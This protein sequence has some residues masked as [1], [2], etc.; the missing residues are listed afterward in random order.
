MC[1]LDARIV[2]KGRQAGDV[3]VPR[4]TVSAAD[5]EAV[6]H[7]AGMDET[8]ARKPSRRASISSEGF[9]EAMRAH[10]AD[11][12]G[13]LKAFLDDIDGIG[14]RPE[15]LASLNLK[16]DQP[17]GRPVNMGYVRRSGEICTEAG[18]WQVDDDLAEDYNLSL[19]RLFGGEV[20]TIRRKRDG[21][22]D[23]WV[24]AADGRLFR[25]EEVADRLGDWRAVMEEFQD[26]IRSRA[27]KLEA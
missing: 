8:E 26:A 15:F 5:G 25:V 3:T 23:R 21:S 7:D 9:F 18:Y 19:A 12:P 17:E 2:Q 24:A 27:V 6:V 14:V 11:V 13:K 4:F 22:R 1:G 16:W 20:R 10:G